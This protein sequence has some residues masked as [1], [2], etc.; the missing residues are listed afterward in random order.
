MLPVRGTRPPSSQRPQQLPAAWDVTLS[1]SEATFVDLDRRG[2][3]ADVVLTVPLGK[4]GLTRRQAAALLEGTASCTWS[5]PGSRAVVP[6]VSLKGDALVV[7]APGV[8]GRGFF[9]VAP[10]LVLTGRDGVV[11]TMTLRTPQATLRERD[12]EIRA[13]WGGS[14]LEERLGVIKGAWTTTKDR[15]SVERRG[16]RDGF[17]GKERKSA[18]RDLREE[19]RELKGSHRTQVR[20]VRQDIREQRDDRREAERRDRRGQVKVQTGQV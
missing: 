20:A 5:A 13:G 18:L 19:R 12:P 11:R 7:K 10:R 6:Q 8:D 3:V 17:E 4:L 2:A 16:V 15:L 14:G 1:P 9:A